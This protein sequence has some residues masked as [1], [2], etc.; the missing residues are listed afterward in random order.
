MKSSETEETRTARLV[1][2]ILNS[3]EKDLQFT[4]V[5]PGDFKTCKLPTLDFQMWVQQE[6]STT[7]RW[8]G[9]AIPGGWGY[10]QPLYPGP[11][12]NQEGRKW[13]PWELRPTQPQ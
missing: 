7:T 9:A 8:G 1:G 12:P 3:L 2:D 5:T 10:R 13:K 4:T 6:E 11:L